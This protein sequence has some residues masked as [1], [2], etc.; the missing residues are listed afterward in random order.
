MPF[1]C[2]VL[3]G[4]ALDI[5][6]NEVLYD[7]P[8]SDAALE[9]V[10]LHN[11]RDRSVALDGISLRFLNAGRDDDARVVWNAAAGTDLAAGGFFVIGETDVASADVFA[12]L[13]LQNGPDALQLVR[14]GLVIDAV[15]WGDEAAAAGEGRAADDPPSRSIGRVPDGI[16]RDD[17]AS[18]FRPLDRATPG[19]VNL[20]ATVLAP[21]PAVVDPPWRAD[22]GPVAIA[23]RWVARGWALRQPGVVEVDAQDLAIEADRG[24]TI[25][26]VRRAALDVGDHQRIH[27]GMPALAE[28]TSIRVGPVDVRLTEVQVR[29]SN[30][31]P[32]W[33]EIANDGTLAVDLEGWS[34]GDATS[35]RALGAVG[36]IPPGARWVLTADR[37][38]WQAFHG[39]GPEVLRPEGGWSTLNDGRVGDPE[40]ADVVRLF[41]AQ[42]RLVDR[43]VYRRDDLGARGASLLRTSVI[44][45]GDVVWMRTAGPP[46]P[47]SSHPAED[48][49]TDRPALALWPDPFTPDGDA[50]GDVLQ[51][52]FDATGADARATVFDLFGEE[53]RRLDGAVGPSRAHWQWDGRDGQ[54]RDVPV[55]AYVLVVHD[56]RRGVVARRVVGLGR[57]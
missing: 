3:A 38:A 9:F 32:E 47:G 36:R 48:L 30:G 22:A 6:I 53:V 43:V 52:V 18:D 46:T 28:T 23:Y 13:D 51:I 27:R 24:D 16:D 25:V 4:V 17:N 29:P 31:E 20:P 55:G 44:V 54:G 1:L 42:A 12:T 7:P 37:A 10:E 57:R 2:A 45:D 8:G 15:A 35:Q 21:L 39:S 41:D 19:A 14:D 33:V 26:I 40:P 56:G 34:V 11:P 50:V 5:V 49:P